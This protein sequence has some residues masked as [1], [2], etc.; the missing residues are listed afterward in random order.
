MIQGYQ[1][2]EICRRLMLTFLILNQQDSPHLL[3]TQCAP[4]RDIFYMEL[5]PFFSYEK[6]I[7]ELRNKGIIINHDECLRFLQDVNYYRLSAFCLIRAIWEEF[8]SA[9]LSDYMNLTASSGHCLSRWSK[10]L[11]SAFVSESLTCLQSV[12]ELLR[13]TH[14]LADGMKATDS[15]CDD[16]MLAIN[17]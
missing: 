5:K 15:E 4:A 17:P 2:P 6:Q 3:P 11:K 10:G 14:W 8:L 1:K 7:A 9:V 16:R 13:K 12:I